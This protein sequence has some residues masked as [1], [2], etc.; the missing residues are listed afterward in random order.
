M[1]KEKMLVQN[2]NQHFIFNALNVIKYAAVTDPRKACRVVDN[3]SDYLRYQLNA[4][5]KGEA[6]CFREE[7]DNVKAYAEIQ[8]LRFEKLHMNYQLEEE[9]FFIPPL[10]VFPVVENA[11]SHGI[12]KKE[13]DGTVTIHSFRNEDAFVI[14]VEDDG[15]GFDQFCQEKFSNVF[16]GINHIRGRLETLMEGELVITSFVNLGT[17]VRISIPIANGIQ[18]KY[19]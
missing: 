2:M 18:R 15:A 14:E 13:D 12:C 5:D 16:G 7:I 9:N 3:F 19:R 1:E 8:M 4:F 17:K 10:T 6:V 11:I